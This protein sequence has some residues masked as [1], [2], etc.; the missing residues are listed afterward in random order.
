M[1][2]REDPA[3]RRTVPKVNALIH[4]A[5]ISREDGMPA[6]RRPCSM[7]RILNARNS[8]SR[9]ARAVPHPVDNMQDAVFRSDNNGKLVFVTSSAARIL[10]HP[11]PEA[12]IGLDVAHDLYFR[13]R[14]GEIHRRPTGWGR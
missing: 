8:R 7:S 14:I 6:H 12:M 2:M 3:A 1:A 4:L 11:S 13:P 10:G 5:R 9:N